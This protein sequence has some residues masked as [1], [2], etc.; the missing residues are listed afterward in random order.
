LFCRN[1]S[2]SAAIS[3]ALPQSLFIYHNL[4]YY[5]ATSADALPVRCAVQGLYIRGGS[6]RTQI[7][8]PM[9]LALLDRRLSCPSRRLWDSQQVLPLVY[10]EVFCCTGGEQKGLG[11]VQAVPSR[12]TLNAEGE[13]CVGCP[14]R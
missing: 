13:L 3:L 12:K 1:L 10:Q 4:S 6:T 8:V 9:P 14:H 11:W 2:S 5:A 7:H